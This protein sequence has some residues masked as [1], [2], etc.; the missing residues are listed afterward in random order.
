MNQVVLNWVE[1]TRVI[2]AE[3]RVEIPL[4][5]FA[6]AYWI[7]DIPLWLVCG[8]EFR[9]NLQLLGIKQI[10]CQWLHRV[11]M[12]TAL[13]SGTYSPNPTH[14]SLHT[15][16]SPP[17]ALN[18]DLFHSVKMSSKLDL[19]FRAP[20]WSF[21]EGHRTTCTKQQHEGEIQSNNCS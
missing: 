3:M 8:K 7:M 2:R 11:H 16:S 9:N 5:Y 18:L 19:A 17:M 15:V 4:V 10:P 1:T 20:V 6:S 12:K 14:H 21:L 13:H